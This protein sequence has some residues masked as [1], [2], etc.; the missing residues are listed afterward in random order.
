[1]VL[2]LPAVPTSAGLTA[3]E[4]AAADRAFAEGLHRPAEGPHRPAD[5]ERAGD[6]AESTRRDQ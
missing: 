4:A 5:G 2:N 1:M 3:T 6:V